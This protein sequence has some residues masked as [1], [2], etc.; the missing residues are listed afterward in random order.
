MKT[1]LKEEQKVKV[2]YPDHSGDHVTTISE[3]RIKWNDET[4][5]WQEW[6]FNQLNESGISHSNYATYELVK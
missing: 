3:L 6:F 4:P 2:T 1:Q 5:E